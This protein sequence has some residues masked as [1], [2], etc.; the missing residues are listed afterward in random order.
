MTIILHIDSSILAANS[1]S[2]QLSAK[3]VTRELELHPDAKIIRRDLVAE[4]VQHL[5]VGHMAAWQGDDS[6]RAA[7]A[8]DL[9]AGETYIEDLFTADMIVI[10]APMYNFTVPSQLK[11]WIDRVVVAGRTF[12]YGP[13][14][15]ESLLPPG[16][17]VIIASARGGIYTGDSPAA[18]L[19]HHESYLRAALGFIGITDVEVIR[20][21]GVAMGEEA[22]ALAI[23]E[24]EADIE[25]LAV[26]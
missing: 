20:A 7:L 16:K 3:I 4:S 9:A 17:K 19:E 15:P 18:T 8:D 6:A 12:Q 21:E 2:R 22:R 11:S 25:A 26:A 24:A 1:V 14:G 13:S 23:T 5:S 10:G